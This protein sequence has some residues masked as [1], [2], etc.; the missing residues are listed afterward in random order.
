LEI[1]GYNLL[2]IIYTTEYQKTGIIILVR[3]DYIKRF[4]HNSVLLKK[5]KKLL[6]N[7]A[8]QTNM[9]WGTNNENINID[10]RK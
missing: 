1:V 9:G 7:L 4:F 10:D 6:R 3:Q 5:F 8:G 2:K